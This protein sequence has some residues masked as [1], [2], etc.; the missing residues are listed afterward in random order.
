MFGTC[1][2]CDLRSDFVTQHM[3]NRARIYIVLVLYTLPPPQKKTTRVS[4]TKIAHILHPLGR[5]LPLTLFPVIHQT[6]FRR[7]SSFSFL[8]LCH[9]STADFSSIELAIAVAIFARLVSTS[10]A[11]VVG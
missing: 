9:V 11:S 6:S 10:S 8:V 1:R 4:V 5:S 7:S 3:S 2:A